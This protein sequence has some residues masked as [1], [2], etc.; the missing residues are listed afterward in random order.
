MVPYKQFA[1]VCADYIEVEF[2]FDAMCKKQNIYK[3][4]KKDENNPNGNVQKR[5]VAEILNKL[6]FGGF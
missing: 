3:M 5:K 4:I 2:N 1:K 6:V